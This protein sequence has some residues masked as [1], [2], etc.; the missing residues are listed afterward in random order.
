VVQFDARHLGTPVVN[1]SR[2]RTRWL[3][4][5]LQPPQLAAVSAAPWDVGGEPSESDQ[6]RQRRFDKVPTA[7]VT[8]VERTINRL[9]GFC[10]VA[11]C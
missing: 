2:V 11:T 9:K 10:R 6:P 3:G 1:C 5:G 4:T 7:S 8:G